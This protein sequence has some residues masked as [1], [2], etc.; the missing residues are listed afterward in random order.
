MTSMYACHGRPGAQIIEDPKKDVM[1]IVMRKKI[2][3]CSRDQGGALVMMI[4]ADF[5]AHDRIRRSEIAFF[6]NSIS[7]GVLHLFG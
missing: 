6:N 1:K 4:P 5:F 3:D 2:G 7:R